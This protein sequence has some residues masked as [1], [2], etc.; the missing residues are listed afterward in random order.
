MSGLADLLEQS[1]KG[2]EFVLGHVRELA[3]V[4]IQHR[5]VEFVEKGVTPQAVRRRDARALDSGVRRHK[6]KGT[7]G[8]H[9]AYARPVAWTM[10][11]ADVVAAGIDHCGFLGFFAHQQRAV[12]LERGDRNDGDFHAT[13]KGRWIPTGYGRDSTLSKRIRRGDAAAAH[14]RKTGSSWLHWARLSDE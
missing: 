14:R 7:A 13:S 6:I 9:G 2:G 10:T 3:I 11:A 12:L 4:A 1:D 5:L 8:L